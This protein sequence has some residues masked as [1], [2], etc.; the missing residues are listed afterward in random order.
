M[1]CTPGL[2]SKAAAPVVATAAAAVLALLVGAACNPPAEVVPARELQI[3]R[4]GATALVMVY[5]RS[6]HTARAGRAIA[7]ELGAD[8]LRLQGRGDEGN[9]FFSTP[10]STSMV[11]V[12]P[13]QVDLGPYR[14]V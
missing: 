12:V 11:P 2:G 4:P 5:S 8:F 13:S 3:L 1:R 14:T 10:S 9:S 6:G 7:D